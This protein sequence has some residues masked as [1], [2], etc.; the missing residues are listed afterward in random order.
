MPSN[1]KVIVAAVKTGTV[2]ILWFDKGEQ[3]PGFFRSAIS[4]PGHPVMFTDTDCRMV[5]EQDRAA[6][7]AT[8][9][10]KMLE[11]LGV[12]AWEFKE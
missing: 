9:D 8:I 10:L 2:R 7:R 6:F 5:A 3:Q 11:M 1:A 12:T 4:Y